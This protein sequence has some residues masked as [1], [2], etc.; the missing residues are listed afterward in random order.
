MLRMA[1]KKVVPEHDVVF[2]EEGAADE[3]PV[4][5]GSSSGQGSRTG[6]A[7]A[8]PPPAPAEEEREAPSRPSSRGTGRPRGGRTSRSRSE[9]E[10]AEPAAPQRIRDVD[11]E[12]DAPAAPRD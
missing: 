12:D 9:G 8:S 10:G 5:R 1:R 11:R 4:S 7:A 3:A 2:E 6:G